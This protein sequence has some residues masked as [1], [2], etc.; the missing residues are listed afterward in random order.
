MGAG[1]RLT[2][3]IEDG[4]RT[5]YCVSSRMSGRTF[6]KPDPGCG[7]VRR[8]HDGHAV[9]LQQQARGLGDVGIVVHDEDA[10]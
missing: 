10:G 6:G 2:G 5:I 9:A 1:S 3:P 4:G 8:R 7:R